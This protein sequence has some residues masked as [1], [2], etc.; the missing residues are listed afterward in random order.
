MKN[1]HGWTLL[2][3]VVVLS[4]GL[5]SCSTPQY[6]L[7][8]E[9]RYGQGEALFQALFV[10]DENTAEVL[11]HKGAPLNYTDQRDNWTA[12][13]YAIY[14]EDW[15]TAK[16]LLEAGSDVNH[17]DFHKRSPLMFAVMRDSITLVKMLI[18]RGADLNA[19]D[20]MERNSLD[21]ALLYDRPGIAKY[22]ALCGVVPTAGKLSG[23][24]VAA[25]DGHQRAVKGKDG[26]GA[27][28]KTE[29]VKLGAAPVVKGAV[30]A[31]AAS[32]VG[33]KGEENKKEGT[34]A[35]SK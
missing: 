27:A 11:I 24:S 33:D 29:E 18:E 15:T 34:A 8:K 9:D 32:V 21:Y 1:W 30:T 19:R 14:Y 7:G 20:D 2:A 5:C 13:I 26:S 25:G 35:D 23:K 16:L 4:L 17:L 12:L 6:N 22:L 3:V 10:Q 28:A 31:K